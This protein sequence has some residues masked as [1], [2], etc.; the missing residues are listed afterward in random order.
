MV[1]RGEEK[2]PTKTRH[3]VVGMLK[4]RAGAPMDVLEINTG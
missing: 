2:V 3:R 4:I 1:H